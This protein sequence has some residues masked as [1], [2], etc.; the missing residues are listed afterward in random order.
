MITP[1][2]GIYEKYLAFTIKTY[3]NNY[4]KSLKY[5]KMNLHQD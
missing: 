2:V 3:T 1:F 5:F 4:Q